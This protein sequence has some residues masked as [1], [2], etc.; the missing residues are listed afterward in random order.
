MKGMRVQKILVVEDEPA[1][2][3]TIT[4]ALRTEGFAVGWCATGEEALRALQSGV[5]ELIILDVGLPDCN[6]FDLCKTIRRTAPIPII[7]L[8]A[9]VDEIDRVVGLEIG[10]DD[11]VSKPFS[12]RELAALVKAVLR[13]A[14]QATEPAE[15][16]ENSTPFAIDQQRMRICY[17]GEALELSRYEF[18]LLEVRLGRLRRRRRGALG[19]QG[20]EA[21]EQGPLER[22]A[23]AVGPVVSLEVRAGHGVIIIAADIAVNIKRGP[24]GRTRHPDGGFPGG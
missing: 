22:G 9:R 20:L 13:R 19:A 18:R 16:V 5:I 6:G 21:I 3:D 15:L 17:F 1:I 4:Y 10:A 12:P 24:E 11:Y 8:T 14:P 23:R 2:A 7:F